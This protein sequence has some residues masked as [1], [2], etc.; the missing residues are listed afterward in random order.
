MDMYVDWVVKEHFESINV[1]LMENATGIQN[2]DAEAVC[3]EIGAG[4]AFLLT[5]DKNLE[6]VLK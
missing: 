2:N 3:R 5:A 4:S 6:V 1:Y